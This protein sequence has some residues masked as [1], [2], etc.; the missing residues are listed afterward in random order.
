MAYTG[1]AET[2]FRAGPDDALIAADAYKRNDI[3]SA[4]IVTTDYNLTLADSPVGIKIKP[5]GM[6]GIGLK[7]PKLDQKD[8]LKSMISNDKSIKN[9]FTNMAD[10]AKSLLSIPGKLL[11]KVEAT[12]NGIVT[13]IKNLSGKSFDLKESL[14]K[15]GN[16]GAIGCTVNSLSD[17]KYA[18]TIVDKGG[19][20]GLIAGV[21]TQASALG[22]NNVFSTISDVVKDK[23]I[24]LNAC[25][26]VLPTASKDIYLLKDLSSTSICSSIKSMLPN[27]SGSSISN[28]KI[29]PGTNSNSLPGVY[30]DLKYTLD[31]V[32]SGWNNTVRDGSKV[33]S[34][35]NTISN[36]AGDFHKTLSSSVMSDYSLLPTTNSTGSY[37]LSTSASDDAFLMT[38][39][40]I[41]EQDIVSLIKRDYPNLPVNINSSITNQLLVNKPQTSSDDS[42]F[43][44][45]VTQSNQTLKLQ[46]DNVT[47]TTTVSPEKT[48]YKISE[49]DNSMQDK[50]Y[51]PEGTYLGKSESSISDILANN[52][53]IRVV[54]TQGPVVNGVHTVNTITTKIKVS[55]NEILSVENGQY[56]LS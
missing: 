2:T 34:G 51:P 13:A 33:L 29:D 54:K 15:L 30:N 45:K 44:Y 24:L 11:G 20:S 36:T 21:T 49:P 5:P 18:L 17:G 22:V 42:S 50:N 43:S 27:I 48:S 10:S 55:T 37:V 53:L 47:S 9:C 39:S 14:E 40:D 6:D 28:F 16:L 4:A 38:T 23:D 12:I 46:T 35:V 52:L 26:Q 7:P 8:V 3:K 19:M 32:D 1:L 25:K 31:K 56:S 41:K